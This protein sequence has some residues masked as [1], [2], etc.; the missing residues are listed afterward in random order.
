MAPELGIPNFDRSGPNDETIYA[1]AVARR[2][3]PIYDDG[4]RLMRTLIDMIGS[5][6]IDPLGGG[7]RFNKLGT[8]VEPAV[9][10][11]AGPWQYSPEYRYCERALRSRTA[12]DL[13]RARMRLP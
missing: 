8:M 3:L 12:F 9:C 13:G 10:H 1:I 4:G 2:G 6:Q 7:T 5:L 11:F